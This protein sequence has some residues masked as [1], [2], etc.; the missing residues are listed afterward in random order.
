MMGV[1]APNL[2]PKAAAATSDYRATFAASYRISQK[3]LAAAHGSPTGSQKATGVGS[4]TQKSAQH[5]GCRREKT[6]CQSITRATSKNPQQTTVTCSPFSVSPSHH[7]QYTFRALFYS[8]PQIQYRGPRPKA[9][10]YMYW[11]ILI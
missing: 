2:R 9:H 3:T 6:E 4:H 7:L 10:W 1:E 11:I 8:Q 5:Q